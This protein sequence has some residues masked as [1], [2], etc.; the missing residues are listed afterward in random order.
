MRARGAKVTDIAVLVV[1]ADDGVMPQTI[2]ALNHAQAAERADRG[3]GE[4]GGQGGRQPRQDPPAAHRVR[5]GGRGV[6]RR[7]HVRR[8]L[9]QAAAQHRRAARGDPA[10]RRCRARPAA[11]PDKDARGVAIEANLDKGRGPV[12]TVLVQSG[13]LAV[14]DAIVAGYR[15]RPGPGHA[16]RERRAHGRRTAVPSG[17]G[18][19]SDLGAPRRRH[20]PGG[21]GRP[22]R[23]PDRREARGRRAAA[24]AGQ[25]PQAHQPRGLHQGPRAGQGRDPQPHP[26]GRRVRFGRGARGRAAQDRGRRARSSCGSSTAVS[27]RS[28]R[29]TSTWPRVDNAIIIGFNVRPAER[30]SELADREGVDIRFYSVIYQAIEDVE[31]ALKGMLKPEF[32][33]VQLGTAEIREV[34]RSSKFGNIAGCIVRSGEIRRN[35]QGPPDPRRRRGGATTWRSTRCGGSRTTP[36]RSARASS[37][38]SA[39]GR[40][41]TSRSTTSS[42]RSRCGRSRARSSAR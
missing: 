2:E 37:A 18:A 16:R 39:S 14:G 1:A 35:A 28:R 26:Q 42:R 34:F 27:V 10:D 8:R 9:G 23:P 15:L 17:A 41:T 13:T 6:R 40:S 4:Q 5:P 20:L 36:P 38:V 29:T 32:E 12:A 25:A 19:R 3:R 31:A 24:H 7:H 11:N 30:V 22:H 33:E 21:A